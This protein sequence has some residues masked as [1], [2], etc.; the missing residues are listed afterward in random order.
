ML[1]YEEAQPMLE[2]SGSFTGDISDFE[3][4]DDTWS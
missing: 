3:L 2:A 4:V 1:N